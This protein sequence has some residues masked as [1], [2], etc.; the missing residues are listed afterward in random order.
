MQA[1]FS[2]VPFGD[3]DPD[4]TITLGLLGEGNVTKPVL[5]VDV[6]GTV[7]NLGKQKGAQGGTGLIVERS[8]KQTIVA[9]GVQ[10]GIVGG[11]V[12]LVTVVVIDGAK[13]ENLH[14]ALTNR[15]A[16]LSGMLV[17][18]KQMHLM[19]AVTKALYRNNKDS[20]HGRTRTHVVDYC[21]VA[22]AQ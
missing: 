19:M 11:R 9:I 20:E 10:H 21:D 3:R 1:P 17:A 4:S 6:R 12:A 18:T 15:Q 2:N 13:M 8:Y 7:F 22:I 14:D 16:D 5:H